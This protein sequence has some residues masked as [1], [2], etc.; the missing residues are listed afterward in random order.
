M[1]IRDSAWTTGDQQA[2]RYSLA[3]RVDEIRWRG[4]ARGKRVIL[5]LKNGDQL[6]LH[7]DSDNV[8]THADGTGEATRDGRQGEDSIGSGS[9]KEVSESAQSRISG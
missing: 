3:K 7:L 6:T 4:S 8:V 2:D 9:A 1:C 5:D